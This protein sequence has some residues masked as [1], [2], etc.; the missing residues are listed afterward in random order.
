[1]KF[2]AAM[3]RMLQC[4]ITNTLETN[5]NRRFQQRNRRYV[6]IRRTKVKF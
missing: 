3:I 6:T 2:K 1:M 4:A 5:K